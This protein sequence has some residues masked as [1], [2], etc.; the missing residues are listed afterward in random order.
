[1]NVSD[2][3][4]VDPGRTTLGDL[5]PEFNAKK[6]RRKKLAGMRI[7]RPKRNILNFIFAI[8]SLRSN[9]KSLAMLII[10]C[11]LGALL[12]VSGSFIIEGEIFPPFENINPVLY[13][14]LEIF[15]GSMLVLG[16]FTRLAMALATIGFG[17]IAFFDIYHGVFD[18]QALMSCVACLVFL[19]FGAGKYSCDFLLRKAIIVKNI[20]RLRKTKKTITTPD[21]SEQ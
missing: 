13:A 7:K 21:L 17:I 1:M 15:A 19:I 18:M 2:T 20:R 9:G 4:S 14:T 16:M 10:R 5:H 3:L 12:I 6:L 8:N 11:A